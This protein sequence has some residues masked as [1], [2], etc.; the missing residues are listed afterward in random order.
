M[1][2]AIPGA[3]T[4]ISAGIDMASS[5]V[6]GKATDVIY[7]KMK[8]KELRD[9]GISEAEISERKKG[10][11]FKYVS[12]TASA[13][14][15]ALGWIPGLKE[16]ISKTSVQATLNLMKHSAFTGSTYESGLARVEAFLD[17][18]T[19]AE[20]R[21]FAEA[22]GINLGKDKETTK[23]SDRTMVSGII[24]KTLAS[25]FATQQTVSTAATASF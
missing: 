10:G 25:L 24:V 8:E 11:E 12:D 21:A 18:K 16:V 17:G 2:L 5:A 19:E 13:I 22:L 15:L 7:S 9:Q 20:F 1:D 6:V 3:G 23:T 14:A 4:A